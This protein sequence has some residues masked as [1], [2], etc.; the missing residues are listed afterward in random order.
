G[1][2]MGQR[3]QELRHVA[4]I[5]GGVIETD[6]HAGRGGEVFQPVPK[7]RQAQAVAFLVREGFRTPTELLLPE[8]LNRIE[9]SGATDRVLGGQQ[10]LLLIL[11]S[12]S[13]VKRLL[14]QEA[15]GGEKAYTVRQLVSDLQA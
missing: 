1:A 7:E 13:R 11:L 14:D 10:L 6:Y 8:I 9:S 12:E 15:L 3:D 4:T 5:V 2:M